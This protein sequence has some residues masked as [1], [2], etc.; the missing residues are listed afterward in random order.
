MVKEN[1]YKFTKKEIERKTPN[2]IG[3]YFLGDIR[4]GKFVIGYVGRSDDSLKTRLL[5]HNHTGKFT[6]FSFQIVKSMREGFIL[7]TEYC[8]LVC[9]RTINKIHPNKPHLL[10]MEHPHD[11]LGRCFKKRF[12]GG[13]H[14]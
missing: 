1:I 4:D 5:H 12:L 9:G 6:H 2:N 13:K 3:I 14:G 7:E 10:Q 8:N 11:V